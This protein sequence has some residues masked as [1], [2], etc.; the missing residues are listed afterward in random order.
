MNSSSA[1]SVFI[2]SSGGW[3]GTLTSSI[4]QANLPY[5]A[6]YNG[7]QWQIQQTG[8]LPSSGS[9][10]GAQQYSI[11]YYSLSGD[12]TQVSGVAS[13]TTNGV[14][15][16][17]WDITGSAAA[18]PVQM[19]L[20]GS[21]VSC[22][23]SPLVCTFSGGGGGLSGMTQYGLP[24]A[25]TSST[26][27]SSIQPGAWTSGHT[28]VPA[29]QPSGSALAPVSLDL[30]TYLASPPAIGGTTPAT[31]AFTTMTVGPPST[32]PGLLSIADPTQGVGNQSNLTGN[33]Q[34]QNY[35]GELKSL[36][37]AVARMN[38]NTAYGGW[39]A[40]I[41]QYRYVIAGDSTAGFHS[42]QLLCDLINR[43]GYAGFES[44]AT[45]YEAAANSCQAGATL[46]GAT[47]TFTGTTYQN[48][49][50]PF[51][52]T[53]SP[54]GIV[55]CLTSG[56]TMT[57]AV[58][59]TYASRADV[60]KVY[61][62][63]E[64]TVA[65]ATGCG[66]GTPGTANFTIT[67]SASGA[68]SGGCSIGSMTGYN[69]S[70]TVGAVFYYRASAPDFDTLTIT[71]S[72]GA[73][74]LMGDQPAAIYDDTRSG[75]IMGNFGRGG[76][77]L[78]DFSSTPS[79][80][81]GP[82][83]ASMMGQPVTITS[84]AITSNVATFVTNTQ[85]PP[86]YAGENVLIGGFTDATCGPV[87][88]GAPL[89]VLEAGLTTTQF[90]AN[91]T[92]ANISTT[93]ATGTAFATDSQ[94]GVAFEM[95]DNPNVQAGTCYGSTTAAPTTWQPYSYWLGN[96]TTSFQ[97]ANSLADWVFFGSYAGY[98]ESDCLKVY[99]ETERE[100]AQNNEGNYIDD[101]FLQSPTEA[102]N[103]G[104][105]I[106]NNIHENTLGQAASS[107]VADRELG[108]ANGF[109]A[110]NAGGPIVNTIGLSA[111]G[112]FVYGG[113]TASNLNGNNLGMCSTTQA[114][115]TGVACGN[116]NGGDGFSIGH[117]YGN[118]TGTEFLDMTSGLQFWNYNHTVDF[119]NLC[120]NSLGTC[121]TNGD[122]SFDQDGSSRAFLDIT[123]HSGG[124][125][126]GQID[127]YQGSTAYW[128]LGTY[129]TG[130]GGGSFGLYNSTGSN[131]TML[132]DTTAISN[133]MHITSTGFT[134]LGTESL[135]GASLTVGVKGTTTG[136]LILNSIGG[137]S[138]A[139]T[140]TPGASLTT[141]ITLTLP[142]ATDTLVG[143]AST[144]T[145]T[146]KSIALSEIN[147]GLTAGG[148]IGASSTTA[149]C[150][151]TF[152]ANTVPKM[153]AASSSCPTSSSITDN[154]T[155]VSTTEALT[156]LSLKA[157]G[158]G[159]VI[160]YATGGSA[161]CAVTQATSR[162]TGVTCNG[163]TGAI[164]LFSA[165]GSATA[166]TFTVTDSSVAATDVVH[167]NQKS[168]SNLY[169]I[170]ITAMSAGSFN[171][172]QFT[173][174]GTTSEAPVFNFAVIKGSTN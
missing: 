145:L 9:V 29:W 149:N 17:G 14:Y 67:S 167:I 113:G 55:T 82:W 3:T 162:T 56:A 91:F 96:M 150:M 58:S 80:V 118:S 174:G 36:G 41:A 90:E 166:A 7:T 39:T 34:R 128:N 15:A 151:T 40:D 49:T 84:C 85:S 65:S 160:G 158:S 62:L 44:G 115:Y 43:Y 78:P 52:F 32:A 125:D 37:T 23:G 61:M 107:Q 81:T 26:A 60:F 169:N 2:P 134:M 79:A 102:V 47:Y 71:A 131:W 19:Q 112:L 75:I 38:F 147:S 171:V 50:G 92:N 120:G 77:S 87:L 57:I 25:A 154:A 142:A 141:A 33:L 86:L 76:I 21:G 156:A 8:T 5:L 140:I 143:R 123:S 45:G 68:C 138:G 89:T 146:N 119:L 70:S 157:T 122:F 66:G 48:S 129:M 124:T 98:P 165:A 137:A 110:N 63:Q 121:Q 104:W 13:P 53:R 101:Y 4:I 116:P 46:W 27:T 100:W 139:A 159:A 94:A 111:V 168:G 83:Y 130:V 170:L 97:T 153:A 126:A 161:G 10:L 133:A 127:F 12:G 88:G 59:G 144:D 136:T 30:A 95:K 132:V 64:P 108:L 173:T 20:T 103:R 22:S 6:C 105:L 152:V 73:V 16:Y 24:V 155:T 31:G 1:A 164:T 42:L 114:A 11:P 51:D 99:N 148:F 35:S 54:N 69:A 135:S 172:T 106:P 93:S 117:L 28:F 72:G 109:M 74:E 18:L 163:G